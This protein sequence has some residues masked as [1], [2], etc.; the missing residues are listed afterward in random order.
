MIL[1]TRH[2]G[3]VVRDIEKSLRFW[4]DVMGLT[5]AV[6]TWDEG[7]YIDTFQALAGV[8]LRYIKL[9]APDGSRIEL[10]HDVH[11]PGTPAPSNVLC[12][13]GIRHIAFAVADAGLAWRTLRANGAETLSEPLLSP[14]GGAKVFFARDPEGNLIEIVEVI[15][16]RTG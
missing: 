12:D 10:L 5:V 14:D 9:D 6:D 4:R 13:P 3:I 1:G 11:H 8:K 16:R 7:R 2:T 15:G